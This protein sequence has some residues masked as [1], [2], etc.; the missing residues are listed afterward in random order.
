MECI[1]AEQ[2]S[3]ADVLR[4]DSLECI[5]NQIFLVVKVN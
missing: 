1:R 3:A 5:P 2:S 4:F